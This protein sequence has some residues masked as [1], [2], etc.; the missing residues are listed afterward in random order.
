MFFKNFPTVTLNIGKKDFKYDDIYRFI[1]VDSVIAETSTNYDW[2]TIADGERP[3]HVSQ[4]L[5]DTPKFYWTFFIINE[6]MKNGISEWPLSDFA[7]DQHVREKYNKYGVV[8]IVP[9]FFGGQGQSFDMMKEIGRANLADLD[10]HLDLMEPWPFSAPITNILNG[11]DISYP[12]LRIR[13]VLSKIHPNRYAK[14]AKWD[15]VK[16]QLWLT[17]IND[18]FFFREVAD[19]VTDGTTLEL[20]LIN[21]IQNIHSAEYE[22][23]EQE[24]AKWRLNTQLK[25]GSSIFEEDMSIKI[26]VDRFYDK[27]ENAP[28]RFIERNTGETYFG[29]YVGLRGGDPIPY[30]EYERALNEEKRRIKVIRPELIHN[31][32]EKY[33]NALISSGRL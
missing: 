9:V 29:E 31:F 11:L 12:Y 25:F 8:S 6:R 14:L 10:Y 19:N 33:Q 20:F 16:Y 26:Y 18:P 24:N 7:L 27:A 22:Q 23:I 5:Y 15:P 28:E 3:D 17:D 4:H 2:Y 21:P 32:V 30:F 1:N 13:R